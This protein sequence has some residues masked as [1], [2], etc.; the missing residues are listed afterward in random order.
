MIFL[1]FKYSHARI[2]K[3]RRAHA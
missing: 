2:I 3:P 1:V